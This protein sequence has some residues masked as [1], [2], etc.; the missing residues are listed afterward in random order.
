MGDPT[1]VSIPREEMF[2]EYQR[3]VK[4]V[5]AWMTSSFKDVALLGVVVAVLSGE[6]GANLLLPS[7]A[8][9]D[10][11]FAWFLSLLVVLAF[12]GFRDQVKQM[13]AWDSVIQAAVLEK[14]LWP[15]DSRVESLPLAQRPMAFCRG[16]RRLQYAYFVPTGLI[17]ACIAALVI[18]LPA[19]V[20]CRHDAGS[21]AAIYALLALALFLVNAFVY[22]KGLRSLGLDDSIWPRD[23]TVAP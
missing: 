3:L 8:S 22:R 6:K 18:G 16:A 13:Q 9:A 10:D 2:K 17:Q 12:L 11:L 7:P 20:L 5:D 21:K 23:K 15:T 1:T 14:H 4:R 19:F